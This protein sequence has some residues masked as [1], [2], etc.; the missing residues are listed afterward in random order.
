MGYAA[1]SDMRFEQLAHYM[2]PP[3]PSPNDCLFFYLIVSQSYAVRLLSVAASCGFCSLFYL[4]HLV[5]A[6]LLRYDLS[7]PSLARCKRIAF[8][9]SRSSPLT[10]R[11]LSHGGYLHTSDTRH[12]ASHLLVVYITHKL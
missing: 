11:T 10:Y 8:L 9:I 12:L 5:A 1:K 4:F 2:P 3:R 6:S 7:S